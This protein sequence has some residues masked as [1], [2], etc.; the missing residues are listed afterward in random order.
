[1][2]GCFCQSRVCFCQQSSQRSI[3]FMDNWCRLRCGFR[4]SYRGRAPAPP[5]TVDLRASNE[6]QD[7]DQSDGGPAQAEISQVGSGIGVKIR[8]SDPEQ[9][10]IEEQQKE[11]AFDRHISLS[12]VPKAACFE[13][14][15]YSRPDRFS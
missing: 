15:L 13:V 14:L 12:L 4:P 11:K 8:S 7:G 2:A 1:M 3:V 5:P 10:D 6:T 9:T